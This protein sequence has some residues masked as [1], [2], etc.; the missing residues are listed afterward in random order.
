MIFVEAKD[1]VDLYFQ[2]K[3]LFNKP[4]VD[5]NSIDKKDADGT[6]VTLPE[7]FCGT[8]W[9]EGGGKISIISNEKTD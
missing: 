6:V 1:L 9:T 3:P 8:I 7:G 5:V 4:I 2:V